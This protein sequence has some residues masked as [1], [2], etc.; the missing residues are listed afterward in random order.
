M[1][2]Y[3]D[4]YIVPH[5]WTILH[6]LAILEPEALELIAHYSDFKV[7]FLLD[8]YGKTPLHYIAASDYVNQQAANIVLK[9]IVSYLEDEDSHHLFE[10]QAIV[11]SMTPLVLFIIAKGTPSLAHRFLNLCFQESPGS[12]GEVRT[13]FG[14]PKTRYTFSSSLILSEETK[15]KIY[16]K[17]EDQ[18]SFYSTLLNLD[19]TFTSNDMFHLALRLSLVEDEQI[20]SSRI[21][22]K[23]IDHL[24]KLSKPMI[25]VL[26]LHFSVLMILLS[27]YIG[28]GTRILALEIII[29]IQGAIVLGSEAI[30]FYNF[31]DQYLSSIWNWLDVM[32][33][34]LVEAYI[35]SRFAGN[36]NA[37]AK[38]WISS[39]ILIVGY[40]RWMAFLRLFQSTSMI[41]SSMSY[42]ESFV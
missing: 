42:S 4:M 13:N 6:L 29:F 15:L 38:A 12:F 5:N 35:I 24:W 2:C 18:I 31:G 21:I 1:L 40:T 27:V 20:F 17:G 41:L 30:Q 9:Y 23:L 39:L 19:Y 7:P 22:Q 26:G 37:L 14:D 16:Q 28:M 34:G 3:Q 36:N 10:R 32:F 11:T 25:K 8:K 33:I